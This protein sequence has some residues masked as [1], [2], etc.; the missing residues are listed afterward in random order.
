MCEKKKMMCITD[1]ILLK[2][3]PSQIFMTIDKN[4]QLL[5]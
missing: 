3:G 2:I 4:L 1:R 5:T